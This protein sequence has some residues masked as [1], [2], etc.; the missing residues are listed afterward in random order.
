MHTRDDALL[1]ALHQARRS[2]GVMQ[3][4]SMRKSESS[5]PSTT[6]RLLHL[7]RQAGNAA[8]GRLLESE[9][10]HLS[11]PPTG[12][13]RSRMASP[14]VDRLL[15]LAKPITF[16]RRLEPAYFDRK[17]TSV[18]L[19]VSR[20]AG[21]GVDAGPA[22]GPR[23]AGTTVDAGSVDAGVG[24]DAGPSGGGAAQ[25]NSPAVQALIA[26]AQDASQPIAQRAVTV[27]NSIVQ[28]F[29]ASDASLVDSVVYHAGQ[30]GLQTTSKGAGASATGVIGVGDD[31]VNGVTQSLISR[32]ALQVGHELEHVRQY[33]SGMVGP[34]RQNEREF[35][36]HHWASTQPDPSGTRPMPHSMRVAMVDE[37]LGYYYCLSPA[38]QQQHA[39]RVQQL[40]TVRAQHD[41]RAGN[42]PTT[43][44][45]TCRH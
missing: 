25:N 27:V 44:P 7:Q 33:R 23:D 17:E 16:Q 30:A 22:A 32:R 5:N 43:P 12:H 11:T 38:L 39:G 15:T 36:A 40:L 45:T 6:A 28:M 37:A 29:Y 3:H 31:F 18:A 21:P 2:G 35:L 10:G 24:Q 26:A 1:G 41:G 4:P 19:V 42:Q 8:V 14:E 34:S 13:R 9:F 20:D